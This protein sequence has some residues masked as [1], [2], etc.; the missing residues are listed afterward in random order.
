LSSKDNA[1]QPPPA[2][3]FARK[4]TEA[5]LDLTGILMDELR[6]ICFTIMPYGRKKTE[7][8]SPSAPAEVDFDALWDKALR[9]AI[10]DLGYQAV[11]ADQDVDALIIHERLERLCFSDLVLAE[12]S[13]ANGNLHYQVG[14][15]QAGRKSGCVL[16]AA[17]WAKPL[18]DVAQMRAVRYSLPEGEITDASAAAVR[19]IIRTKV[20]SLAPSASPIHTL[21]P[22][23]PDAVDRQRVN[24]VRRQLDSLITFQARVSVVR[25][26]P[27]DVQIQKAEELVRIYSEPPISAPIAHGLLKLLEHVG[28]WQALIDFAAK[29]PG[30]LATTAEVMQFAS[31][32]WSRM[33]GH[34]RAIGALETLI[35]TA[36]PT[37]EREALIG[38]RY[39]KLFNEARD[40]AQKLRYLEKAIHHYERGMMLDLNDYQSSCN[41]P[42]LYRARGRKGDEEKARAVA[43]L[44]YFASR[45]MKERDPTDPM[46]RQIML[47]AAFDTS[48]VEAAE[49]LY[50]EIVAEGAAAW[51]LHNV[52]GLLE[53]SCKHASG[54]KRRKAL[55]DVLQRLRQL[56]QEEQE[57]ARAAA[58]T[59]SPRRQL[60]YREG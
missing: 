6:P 51:R 43:Q 45:R 25:A 19:E 37:S 53:R 57:A 55:R 12:M 15:R 13:I 11:R 60:A 29:L 36:G 58:G 7:Q 21:L 48:D 5:G 4:Q 39:R 22:G 32:A 50:E 49:S 34:S 35:E 24:R 44:V 31:L 17:D 47:T 40:S 52:I 41:L 14:V 46:V 1:S 59:L 30:E 9:P 20:R 10:E 28:A 18:F 42:R 38:G 23:F 3:R 27:R 2:D 33:A 8:S 54:S 56:L 16:L 26:A